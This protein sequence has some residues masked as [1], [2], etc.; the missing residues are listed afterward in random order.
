MAVMQTPWWFDR[1]AVGVMLGIPPV[2]EVDDDRED[3]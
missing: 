3:F 1:D 2:E